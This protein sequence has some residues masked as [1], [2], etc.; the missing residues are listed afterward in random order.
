MEGD[1]EARIRELE[2]ELLLA[3][4]LLAAER[5]RVQ[6]ARQEV[7]DQSSRITRAAE[8][9]TDSHALI[10]SWIAAFDLQLDDG[11]NYKITPLI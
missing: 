8:Y 6:E 10:D 9:V 4:T 5:E 7:A 2:D 1:A 3:R 11:K